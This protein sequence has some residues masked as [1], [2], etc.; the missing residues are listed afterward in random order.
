M[1]RAA[2]YLH[3]PFCARKCAYCD[4]V[5]YAGR[6]D[7]MRPYTDALVRE[8]AGWSRAFP[9]LEVPTIYI[10]GGTPSLLPDGCVARILEGARALFRV[11]P[12]AEI[13]LEANPGTLDAKRLDEY[14]KAG[15]NRL[16][17]GLQ[18]S[19]DGL[20][21]AIG[22]AHTVRD[23]TGATAL[24][25]DAGFFNLSVDVMY[26]L[27]GQ[28]VSD[29]LD[30][31]EMAA[32]AGAQH[33][34]AYALTLEAG[35]PLADAVHAGETVLPDED[36][37][38]EMADAGAAR[39]ERLGLARYEISNYARPGFHSCHNMT[40]W[41]NGPYIG[42]GAAAHSCVGM[43]DGAERLENTPDLDEYI[44]RCME[45]ENPAAARIKISKQESMFETMMLGLR[46]TEGVDMEAFAKRYGV[47]ADNIYKKQLAEL[48]EQEMIYIEKGRIRPTALGLDFHSRVALQFM[49]KSA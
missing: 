36:A 22:R 48:S 39:L 24:A 19:R 30:A 2:L 49:E 43:G 38:W 18:A 5:S 42:A 31:A 29:H 15:V 21:R 17:V 11:A 16:S 13:T 47:S 3:I 9:G 7:R 20:L 33:V 12:D 25:R 37:V 14:A 34:S 1:D 35:T 4:F 27:P 10:G 32:G 44:T 45:G 46:T 41:R 40:Y 23:F 26:G 28:T 8:L 6:A